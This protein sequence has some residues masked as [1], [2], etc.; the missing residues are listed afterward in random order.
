MLSIYL[1]KSIHFIFI[2]SAEKSGEKGLKSL[3]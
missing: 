2:S 1:S 3:F